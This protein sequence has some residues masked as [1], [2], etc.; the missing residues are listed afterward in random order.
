MQ[1]LLTSRSVIADKIYKKF[2]QSAY[3]I[4][5]QK[6]KVIYTKEGIMREI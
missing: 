3:D 5:K 4:H 6:L 2:S 1:N